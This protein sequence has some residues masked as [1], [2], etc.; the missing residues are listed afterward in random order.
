MP[1]VE[2]SLQT[3]LTFQKKEAV[4]LLLEQ[5]RIHMHKNSN[6]IKIEIVLFYSISCVYVYEFVLINQC[7]YINT[8]D[9]IH[10]VGAC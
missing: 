6:K 8:I 4:E 10:T 7:D 1:L 2:Y 5:N 3:Q 9:D